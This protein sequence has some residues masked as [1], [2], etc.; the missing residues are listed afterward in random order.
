MDLVILNGSHSITSSVTP[1]G[2]NLYVD[3]HCHIAVRLL[4]L[5][6]H[7]TTTRW[8]DGTGRDGQ[9]QGQGSSDHESMPPPGVLG[10]SS[11]T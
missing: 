3:S 2:S 10:S 5:G 6:P 11:T 9:T 1:P 4:A 7:N 8:G